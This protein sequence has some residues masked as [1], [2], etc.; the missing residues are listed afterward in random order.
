MVIRALRLTTPP[1]PG[2]LPRPSSACRRVS[3]GHRSAGSLWSRA[4]AH[5]A[6]RLGAEGL[7]KVMHAAITDHCPA[8]RYHP[9]MVP[10]FLPLFGDVLATLPFFGVWFRVSSLQFLVSSF[11]RLPVSSGHQKSEIGFLVSSFRRHDLRA[12]HGITVRWVLMI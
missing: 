2:R 8:L 4:G 9:A 12:R 11:W 6:S 5:Q 1:G 10:F 7:G 3:A